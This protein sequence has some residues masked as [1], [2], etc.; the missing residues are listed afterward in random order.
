MLNLAYNQRPQY[1]DNDGKPL[2]GGRVTFFD[3]NTTTLK[4]IYADPEGVTQLTNPLYLDIGGFVPVSGVFYGEGNYTV[5]VEKLINPGSPTPT[6]AEE[7]TVP[8]VPGSVLDSIVG[9]TT[10]TLQSVE[11]IQSLPLN[12]YAYVYCLK[13]YAG[14]VLDSGG[15]WFQWMP[16]STAPTDLGS[17]FALSASPAVGRYVRIYPSN[18][19]LSAY[20]GVVPGRNVDMSSRL[21]QAA[22]WASA[23]KLGLVLS[24]GDIQLSGTTNLYAPSITVSE[25]FRAVRL[26]ALNYTE[27][28]LYSDNIKVEGSGPFVALSPLPP[29]FLKIHSGQPMDI[30]PKWWGAVADNT[31]DAYSAFT[32]AQDSVNLSPGSTLYVD[33]NYKLTGAGGGSPTITFTNLYVTYGSV[34]TSYLGNHLTK[35]TSAPKYDAGHSNFLKGSAA[36]DLGT[37]YSK[38]P[39]DVSWFIS[40]TPSLQEFESLPSVV[41]DDTDTS[42]G[43]GTLIWSPGSYTF[44]FDNPYSAPTKLTSVI[45]PG[46]YINMASGNVYMGKVLV[47]RQY[48]LSGSKYPIL[49]AGEIVYPEWWGQRSDG[50]WHTQL[51]NA[52]GCAKVYG[53]LI[54]GQG[55]VY[56]LGTN[57][58]NLPATGSVN[59]KGCNFDINIANTGVF[60]T[61]SVGCSIKLDS[62]YIPG[63]LNIQT[64]STLIMTNIQHP[65]NVNTNGVV[66]ASS[67]YCDNFNSSQDSGIDFYGLREFINSSSRFSI[68]VI[69]PYR[70]VIANNA[71]EYITFNTSTVGFIADGVSVTG[72]LCTQIS[73]SGPF[74]AYGHNAV[75]K[76]NTSRNGNVLNSTYTY[77][78]FEGSLN[79]GFNQELFFDNAILTPNS[80]FRNS[81]NPKFASIQC[82][83]IDNNFADLALYRAFQYTAGTFNKSY[84][85]PDGRM[86]FNLYN[87]SAQQHLF[88]YVCEIDWEAP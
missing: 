30:D 83:Y 62:C 84:T 29:T 33:G 3:V 11:D 47:G 38:V 87:N 35:L 37:W 21:L 1:L 54:D 9:V 65:G 52:M 28:N 78:K 43:Y 63:L 34:I 46:C 31:T 58:L 85:D 69:D 67:I 68:N 12:Q 10:K 57:Q 49:A 51:N 59:I 23:N 32:S 5:L 27:L 24:P 50:L 61:A 86:C 8:D 64:T 42:N 19:V 72:N 26:V 2:S 41:L 88:T 76:N 6:Y 79:S 56:A 71:M 60:A 70:V 15:G 81:V 77:I 55:A 40:N 20:Y 66:K 7:Y 16:A 39:V 36:G 17:V 25:G 14:D 48:W 22:A 73:S 74:A 44:A 18:K 53:N 80:I 75:V 82:T 4:P 45:Q 13:Y